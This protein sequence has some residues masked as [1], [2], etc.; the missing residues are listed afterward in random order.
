MA[1]HR[2]KPEPKHVLDLIRKHGKNTTPVPP[3]PP[4]SLPGVIPAE[5][6]WS[7]FRKRRR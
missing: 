6:L 4:P 2:K 1:A 5:S 7:R 3:V